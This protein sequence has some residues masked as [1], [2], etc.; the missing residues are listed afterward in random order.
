VPVRQDSFV[1]ACIVNRRLTDKD[2]SLLR[3]KAVLVT[4]LEFEG[5]GERR[6][7][8]KLKYDEVKRSAGSAD[9]GVE[10]EK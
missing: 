6:R 8:S 9:S 4:S 7:Q 2:W 10:G 1:S 5:T 3:N